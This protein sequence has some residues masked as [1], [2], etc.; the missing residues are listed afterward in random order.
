MDLRLN[1]TLVEFA[2]RE[3]LSSAEAMWS[4]L[5]GREAGVVDCEFFLHALTSKSSHSESG[6]FCFSRPRA[7]MVWKAL[8]SARLAADGKVNTNSN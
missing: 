1:N 4:L 2:M 6:S 8:V 7:A 3:S 5:F